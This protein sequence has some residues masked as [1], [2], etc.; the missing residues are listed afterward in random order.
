VRIDLAALT[1]GVNLDDP[2]ATCMSGPG[3]GDCAPWFAAL[4]LPWGDDP[5][6][7]AAQTV[8]SVR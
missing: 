8:F 2:M 5:G 1:A 6:D 7:P 3:M 4:G